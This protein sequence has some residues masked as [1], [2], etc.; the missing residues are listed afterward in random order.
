[1]YNTR[2]LDVMTRF[3]ALDPWIGHHGALVIL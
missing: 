3:T 1:M 2:E